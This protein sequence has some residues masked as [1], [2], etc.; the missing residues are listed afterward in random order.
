MYLFF[1]RLLAALAATLL[2]LLGGVALAQPAYAAGG[3]CTATIFDPANSLYASQKEGLARWGWVYA[4]NGAELHVIIAPELMDDGTVVPHG[5]VGNGQYVDQHAIWR[6]V[7]T[8]KDSCPS[9]S[10][11]DGMRIRDG[12]AIV[13]VSPVNKQITYASGEGLAQLDAA[14]LELV[15]G[16]I[17]KGYDGSQPEA[18]FHEGIRNL[19]WFLFAGN[20]MRMIAPLVV[21]VV[22]LSAVVWLLRRRGVTHR[23]S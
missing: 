7:L 21:S 23:R 16:P 17:I 6:Y 4:L 1:R 11:S 22:A 20:L 13:A 19:T 10:T 14:Q 3:F 5:K 2:T 18:G 15:L 12:L 9:W 8:M